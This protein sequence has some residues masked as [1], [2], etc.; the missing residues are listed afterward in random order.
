MTT[1]ISRKIQHT[2]FLLSSASP[3]FLSFC[4]HIYRS[5]STYLKIIFMIYLSTYH[6]SSYY[7]SIYIYLFIFLINHCDILSLS[8]PSRISQNKDI[9]NTPTKLSPNL[10]KF[11]FFFQYHITTRQHSK[12]PSCSQNVSYNLGFLK[13][14]TLVRRHTLY[15]IIK[16]FINL[17]VTSSFSLVDIWVSLSLSLFFPC[18]YAN[19]PFSRFI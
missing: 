2:F 7:L 11:I 13:N 15:L 18:V 3:T 8:S 17:E 4:L 9:A 5:I 14:Q 19:V 10:Q 6:S 12:V 1:Y 16:G